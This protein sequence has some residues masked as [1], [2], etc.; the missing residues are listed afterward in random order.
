MNPKV[1]VAIAVTA[2]ILGILNLILL[3]FPPQ[4]IP[5]DVAQK[6]PLTVS[7]IRITGGQDYL[8]TDRFVVDVTLNLPDEIP[9]LFNCTIQAEYLTVD[10][11][12]KT[13]SKN[14]G[15]VNYGDYGTEQ[16]RLDT[17][18]AYEDEP[19]SI[20]W[21]LYDGA[22]LKVEAYGYLKP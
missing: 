19:P 21:L 4:S 14:I 20:G 1:L 9:T 13:T 2:L 7:N 18:F 5:T 17:D 22:N 16:L 8:G 15:I 10:N 3:L 11:V 12:W 6:I